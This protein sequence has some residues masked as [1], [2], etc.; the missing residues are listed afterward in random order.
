MTWNRFLCIPM[1]LSLM[2][3]HM[4]LTFPQGVTSKWEAISH[5]TWFFS[6]L[7]LRE[8]TWCL[9]SQ[10]WECESLHIAAKIA[11]ST[12]AVL[13]MISEKSLD[14][15]F[16]LLL[17]FFLYW[18]LRF[19]CFL[20]LSVPWSS[21]FLRY[22]YL[23][24]LLQSSSCLGG[25][26]FFL[27]LFFFWVFVLYKQMTSSSSISAVAITILEVPTEGFTVVC[28]KDCCQFHVNL[29]KW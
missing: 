13:C 14:D 18:P 15:D 27:S 9:W 2:Q 16:W 25:L 6:W 23:L 19:E 26:S 4:S 12:L 22:R 21:F 8:L 10:V 11:R 5:A 7:L 20:Q 29:D 3:P 24:I 1:L 17:I 28:V